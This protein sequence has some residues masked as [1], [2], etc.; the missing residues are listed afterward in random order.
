VSEVL[1]AEEN[2]LEESK[3][4]AIKETPFYQKYKI[5]LSIA[6]AVLVVATSAASYYKNTKIKDELIN[7]MKEYQEG[8][9]MIGGEMKYDSIECGGLIATDCE[10]KGIKLS[11]MGQEQFSIG[12]LRLGDVGELSELKTFSEGKD[13][14][15]S[16]DIEADEVVLPK[17]LLAQ[18]I[19]Q[20]VSNA[21][22]QSTLDKLN[23]INFA[24]KG[25]VEGHSMHVKRLEVDQLRIDNAIMPFEFS[26][27]AREIK[28]ETP[29]SMIL[30]SFE[31]GI[32]NRAVSDVTYE[33]V[34]R[35]ADG[36][37]PQEQGVFLKE[38]GLSAAD[39]ND[40]AK[41]AK[42]INSAIAKRFESDLTSASGVAEKDLIQAMVKMLKGET[43]TIALI[44]QNQKEL[45]MAQI[46]NALIQSATMGDAEG[47]KFMED[48]FKIEVSTD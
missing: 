2:Q 31:L 19:A 21:F 35:F 34:K 46:Q 12:S 44:G 25:D 30:E 29:D 45:T 26:M 23:S 8:L 37:N 47:R 13:I 41:A 42:A 33:S 32:E 24:L 6:A 4:E 7:A 17:P 5:H 28:S 14:D 3:P 11:V 10:I 27:D 15:A 48:K 18:L 9:V 39:L 40:K 16:F 22:Q 20:N 36:L 1:P 43:S 38:F